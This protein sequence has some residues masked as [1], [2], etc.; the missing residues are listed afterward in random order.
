MYS[1]I[2]YIYTSALAKNNFRVMRLQLQESVNSKGI[3]FTIYRHRT[4][5]MS[6]YNHTPHKSLQQRLKHLWSMLMFFRLMM[7][8]LWIYPLLLLTFCRSM[9]MFFLRT[10]HRV[11]LRSVALSIKLISSPAL[12]LQTVP[13]T[14]QIQMRRRRSSARCRRCLIKVKFVSLLALARFL[15]YSFQRKM[16]HGVCA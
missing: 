11:F 10:Y 9:L 2:R 4:Q 6:N 12:L 3:L 13:R 15:F 16:G 7:H 14:V 5:P 1:N 8:R